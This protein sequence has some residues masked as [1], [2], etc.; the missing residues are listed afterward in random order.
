MKQLSELVDTKVVDASG[1]PIG[2]VD[3]L[4]LDTRSGRI[5]RIIVKTPDLTRFSHDWADLIVRVHQ[6]M[7]KAGFRS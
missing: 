4:I 7:V 6:F 2:S 3:E 1:E 5:D